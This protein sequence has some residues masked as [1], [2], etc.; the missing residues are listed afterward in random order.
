MV[1][2]LPL[3]ATLMADD[4]DRNKSIHFNIP[5]QRADLALTQFAEQADLTL[6]FPF[7]DVREKTANRLVGE[8]LIEDAVDVLLSGTG[9]T[10]TL[11]NQL[12]LNIA[13]D[14]KSEPEGDEMNVKK[15]AGLGA[16]LA[17]L[18]SI[19][20]NAQEPAETDT[21]EA[22]Q[23]LEEILVT[24]SRIRG[25][26]NASPVVT[27]T[28]QEIER[29]GFATVEEIVD[30][31]PQNFG[32]GATQ[33]TL[34]DLNSANTSVGGIVEAHAGGTS[35]N[36]R[37]LGAGATL[38]LVNGR[39]TSPSGRSARFSDISG[40][41]VTA[42]ERVEVLTDGASAIYGSDAIG[43]VVNFILRDDYEGA[44]TRLRY[45]SDSGG[46]TSEVLF[47]QSFG[48]SWNDGNILFSYEYYKRDS[49]ANVDRDFTAS[50]D[51]T[52]FGGTDWRTPGGNPAN[53]SAGG[54]LWAIPAGQDGTL[55]TAAD[56]P[57]DAAGVPTTPLNLH[58]IR[59]LENLLP[60]TERHSVFLSLSQ[61]IGTAELF[62][63]ARFS[64]REDENLS[65]FTTFDFD[66]PDTNPFFV[67]P[68]GTGLTTVRIDNYS[69]GEDIGP[70]VITA[71][72]DS[73]AGT[74]GLRFDIGSDW[75]GELV[76]LWAKEESNRATSNAVDEIALANAINQTDPNLAFN[77]FGD[78]SNTNPAVLDG[79]RRQPVKQQGTTAENEFWSVSLNVDGTA[80]E[81][82]GGAVQ[83][84][85]GIE[86][87]EDSL[88]TLPSPATPELG[89]DTS[90]DVLAVY[91]ELFFP[92]VGD[93]NSRPG[94]QRLEVSVAARYE[95]YSD[96]GDTTNP[97]V[98][99]VWS[100]TQSLTFR[101]T[102]GSSFQAPPLFDLDVSNLDNNT[103]VYL[104]QL[105]ADLGII[106]F[107]AL[108]LTGANENL[109]PEEAVTWIA[110]LQWDPKNIKGLSLDVTY[111]NIDFEDRIDLPFA[112]FV[113]GFT[114]PRFASL[115][116]TAPT[117]EQIA[118]LVND[119][120]WNEVFGV[121]AADVLSGVAPVDGILD[122]RRN[123]LSRSVVTGTELLLSYQFETTVGL[124]DIGLN[125][126][127]LF[128]FER[129]FVAA[130]PLVDEVDTLGRPIDLRARGSVSWSREGWS[131]S[132]F[133]N[134]ADGYTD[135]VSSPE[136]TIDSWTTVDL[137]IAYDT[138]DNPGFLSDTRF[139]L[140]TQNL[141]DED[142]PFADTLNG[143]AY[144]S[145]NHNPLG[146]FIAFNI[147]KEW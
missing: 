113:V 13:T 134:Y 141:F 11:K 102:Y 7:D 19:G 143:L 20:A 109:Q 139:S 104:P 74:L 12:V 124:F 38:I 30:K 3:S 49:L 16:L 72:S 79:L 32:A 59:A 58:D 64:T 115:L 61:D 81:V 66:V 93:S 28:R 73:Y 112:N 94:L 92:L 21:D 69:F 82:P 71:E 34:T 146:R 86:F 127:Y 145:A 133:L 39:R 138:G 63:D 40:I 36:L 47:G 89:S 140:T 129:A 84:A 142:P 97:K 111:F 23:E 117:T 136:R 137:T 128:D 118:A 76:G 77:P 57:V 87:R 114:D 35:V 24:G 126:T 31:L 56:F 50:Q 107:P 122:A 15:K 95:D 88:L 96:F 121:P 99:L 45:G 65:N 51:L 18:F 144:D 43:G 75:N 42:I 25:A 67:D 100:P 70:S 78:G 85:T 91:A 33:D 147:T 2:L 80:F 101:G 44:E 123:N 125:A 106:P 54:Q 37:G 116:N 52:R 132:G 62:A 90:R 60:E 9:L 83:I 55:L 5:Q 130:D 120:R 119:P 17:G 46:D 6:V 53:I 22:A 14:S 103:I 8:Y 10:P 4:S 29:A 98:G 135:N 131:V 48:K 110:G 68:T 108:I 41:P 1:V 26:Q 105:F 27:I